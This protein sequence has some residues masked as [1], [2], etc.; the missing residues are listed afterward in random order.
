MGWNEVVVTQPHPILK[1]VEV[2]NEFYFVHSY[3]PLPSDPSQ[4]FASCEYGLTFPAAIGHGNLFATQ[5]HP[6][7]SGPVGLGLLRNFSAW[8][9]TV[10]EIHHA[11]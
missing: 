7:K 8:D 5:F 6:E 10:E 3:Y 9:G 11:E 4:V 2:G 1:D